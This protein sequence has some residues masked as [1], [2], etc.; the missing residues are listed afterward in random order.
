MHFNNL[1]DFQTHASV[2][3]KANLSTENIAS[4]RNDMLTKPMGSLGRLEEI[5][6]W[7]AAWQGQNPPTFT[8]SQIVIFAGNHGVCD[9]G[10][11][12]F[13]PDVTVQMVA[14]FEQGG[15]AINQ[16][17][18]AFGARFSIIPLDLENPTKDFTKSSAM[19]EAECVHALNI[20]WQAVDEQS[21]FLVVGEMG[22]GN[23]TVAAAMCAALFGGGGSKWAGPGTGIDQKGVSHKANVIDQAIALHSNHLINPLEILRFLGGRE[24]AA[25]IGAIAA[26]RH[27]GVP[28]I[29]DGFVVCAAAAVLHTLSGT[30][31]DH[32]LAGHCSAEPGHAHLL[33][34][35][36]KEPLLRLGMRLGE[37]SGAALALGI[38]K[39]AIA[40]HAGMASFAEAGVS[41]QED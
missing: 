11:S 32:C 4:A 19:D 8:S 9:Q 20:G 24:I 29:L 13:P 41:S 6:I 30:A 34:Q 27:H 31:L 17:A 7:A 18:N 25:M 2:P 33:K 12:A 14:N 16:L 40:T 22:I 26:A 1:A 5:A 21:D 37:G 28:V 10:I 38:V 15:A 36:G 35:L 23:T 3:Q 39:G